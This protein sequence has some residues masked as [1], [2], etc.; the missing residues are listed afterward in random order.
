[1]G[2]Y[3][4][5]LKLTCKR[6]TC[7]TQAALHAGETPDSP[8]YGNRRTGE[9]PQDPQGFPAELHRPRLIPGQQRRQPLQGQSHESQ[10]EKFEY[11][12]WEADQAARKLQSLGTMVYPPG[13]KAAIDWGILAG[14]VLHTFHA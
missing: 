11:G 3:P 1:M 6:Y 12:S 10:E 9:Q 7:A 14:G 13:N 8:N 2:V 4:H 5:P